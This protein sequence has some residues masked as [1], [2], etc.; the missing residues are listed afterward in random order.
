MI[1]PKNENDEECFKW[2]V[3]AALHYKEIGK[4]PQRI[5]NIMRCTNNYSWSG[6]EFPVAINKISEFEKN[7][8]IP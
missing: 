7:N 3:I 1:N 2:A 4:N 6:L 8:N 5:S